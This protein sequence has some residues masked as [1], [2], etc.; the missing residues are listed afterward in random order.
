MTGQSVG[1]HGNPLRAWGR[2]A[3]YGLRARPDV[4]IL[5]LQR[6]LEVMERMLDV[7]VQERPWESRFR[8][9]LTPHQFSDV[10]L[11][12]IGSKHDGGYVI[13]SDVAAS[14]AGVV[15]IG[16]GD[17]NGAD[18]DLAASGLS[19][20]AW[21]HTVRRLPKSHERITFHRVGL[22]SEPSAGLLTL[23]SITSQSF[24]DASKN[25]ILMMD[26]EGAEWNALGN[27]DVETL[28]RYSII[29][30]EMHGLGDLLIDPEPYL[31]VFERLAAHF[32]VVCVHPNN[33]SA[34]WSLPTMNLPDAIEV[35]YLRRDVAV[36]AKRVGNS[37]LA[38]LAPC[39]ADLPE[40]PLTW[41]PV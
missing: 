41:V 18:V 22:G 21:D 24:G 1:R 6:R 16:V 30:V 7:G 3:F 23:A 2:R 29:V 20:H 40:V 11:R 15:S 5:K 34:V 19:V 13:P 39:C 26:A 27:C 10:R 32:E 31:A 17:D 14:A 37:P 4:Q 25:L 9:L 36:G 12:R 35:T 28:L 8:D 38:L 33:Y